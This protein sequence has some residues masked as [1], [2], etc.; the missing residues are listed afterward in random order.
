MYFCYVV[1]WYNTCISVTALD[2]TTHV[3]SSNLKYAAT[4]RACQ[5][6]MKSFTDNCVA[7]CVT[8]SAVGRVVSVVISE[9]IL[10]KMLVLGINE[11]V[12]HSRCIPNAI[13]A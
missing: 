13:T 12:V 2:G 3:F 6:Q 9:G 5:R 8:K 10:Y 7:R 11:M 4:W 1:G